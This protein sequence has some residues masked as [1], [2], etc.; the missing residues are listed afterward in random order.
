MRLLPCLTC[1]FWLAPLALQAGDT[2]VTVSLARVQEYRTREPGTAG[3]STLS[4]VVCLKGDPVK[5]ALEAGDI[6]ITE[7]TD[8]L[9]ATLKAHES[10]GHYVSFNRR[11]G[12]NSTDDTAQLN[13]DLDAP[14]RQATSLKKI[15][16]TLKIRTYR[17]QAVR[18]E[19][20]LK[21]VNQSIDHP[22]FKAHE[23]QVRV[24]DARQALPG[25]DPMQA[26]EL[27]T[28]TVSIE[29]SGEK[30]VI[31]GMDLITPDDKP[32]AARPTSF[33][34]GRY[35]Y[36]SRQSDTDL[37]ANTIAQVFIAMDTKEITVPFTLENVPLP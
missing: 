34:A 5:Q 23:V 17:Y 31:N 9:G 24:V 37:P 19:D 20:V 33:G 3:D 12:G 13:I 35:T 18:I 2:P 29:V 21:K 6:E 28:R 26:K 8:N 36:Y 15:S 22:I 11:L 16:G 32:L 25:T 1:V 30:E 14:S 4:V 27:A 7:A 10:A